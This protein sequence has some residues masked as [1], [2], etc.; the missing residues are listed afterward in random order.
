MYQIY[1]RRFTLSCHLIPTI[2]SEVK[3]FNPRLTKEDL[4]AVFVSCLVAVTKYLKGKNNLRRGEMIWDH[5]V[6][7][8]GS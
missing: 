4:R 6:G 3:T 5:S 1:D 8:S 7:P 2:L